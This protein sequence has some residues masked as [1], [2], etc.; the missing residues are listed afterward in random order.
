MNIVLLGAPGAGKGTQAAQLAASLK[1]PHISTG[2]IFRKNMDEKTPIGLVARSYIDLGKLV[3]DDVTTE[4]VRARL[5]EAD[6][7]EGFILDGFPRTVAQAEALSRFSEIDAVID[8]DVP[9]EK[10]MKRLTGRRVCA[11][12]HESF[13]VD[14]IGARSDCP[15]CGGELTHRDDDKEET[16]K[17]RLEVYK[18]QTEP[19]ISFYKKSDKLIAVN[20]DQPVQKVTEEI[21]ARLKK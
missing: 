11:S 17:K 15:H 12:C 2:D 13:H 3:P 5:E 20:G 9:L 1:I 21:F 16:V 10:L 19:L 4:I 7:K 6:C 8:V 18:A 14:F